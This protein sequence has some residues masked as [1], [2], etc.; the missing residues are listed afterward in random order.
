MF[1]AAIAKLASRQHGLFSRAQ[2]AD[3]GGREWLIH[4][5][6]RSGRW[7]HEAEGVYGLPGWPDSWWRRLWRA[8]LATGPQCVVCLEAAAAIHGLTN[9]GLGRIVLFT[10]HGDHH[11]HRLCEMRQST[12]I[13][14]E[15]VEVV[16]GLRVTTVARTLCDL[17]RFVGEQRLAVAVED[18]H[19][20][21]ACRL[22][23]LQLLLDELRRPGKRG[24]KLVA[25]ILAERG[26]GFVPSESWL[27][28]RL[29]SILKDAG[30]PRPRVQAPLP[31]RPDLPQR[32][33][34][35]YEREQVLLEADGRRWHVRVDQMATDRR[36]DREALN[37]GWRPY[38]F[39]YQELKYEPTIV[40]QT[41]RDALAA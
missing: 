16:R 19:I 24:M 36:R 38:R 2:V 29:L 25:K 13:R 9:F 6:L 37:H 28:R 10:P 17:A 20:S 34:A 14:P 39:V 27:E 35:L 7:T 5:R 18:A 15:H 21:G 33:D 12:D 3:L 8:Y 32:T 4:A 1:D 26:P 22:D 23:E 40:V 31:W 11:W 41:V 30:L